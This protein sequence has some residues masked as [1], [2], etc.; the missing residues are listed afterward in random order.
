MSD[1]RGGLHYFWYLKKTS[2]PPIIASGALKIVKNGIK[3]RKLWLLKVE[4]VKNS[5]KQTTKCY[6]SNSPN[7]NKIP[8]MLL[9]CY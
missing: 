2:T 6:K 4:G 7:T 8:C 1:A 3:L 5:K 9:C